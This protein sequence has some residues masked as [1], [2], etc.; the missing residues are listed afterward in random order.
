MKGAFQTDREI[1]KNP[2][3]TD[4]VAFRI[5]FYIYGNAVFAKEGVDV[6]GIHLERGQFLRS[7]RNLKQD[8]EYLDKRSFKEYSISTI[9]RKVEKLVKDARIK[10]RST[11]YGTLFTVLNYEEYQGFER[12]QKSSSETATEQQQN[13]NETATERQSNNNKNVNNVKNEKNKTTT[14]DRQKVFNF[15]EQG[16]FGQLG[17][18]QIQNIDEEI[19]DFM[20][21]G[22]SEPEHMVVLGLQEALNNN[23]RKWSYARAVMHS[24]QDNQV[25]SANDVEA[26]K[27]S[28][29][30]TA[31][32]PKPKD[33]SHNLPY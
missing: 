16:G 24:W 20:M 22:S 32:Q 25:L 1:F 33:P 17:S 9:Q 2:I 29:K 8:L 30:P 18:F 23:V 15:F 21:A 4:V 5:F 27:A 28:H 13:T 12:F 11:E 26:Y 19:K 3:W 7:Y 6:A 14:T 10:V 31:P